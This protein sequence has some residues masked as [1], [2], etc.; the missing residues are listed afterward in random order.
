M[1]RQDLFRQYKVTPTKECLLELLGAYQ[2]SVYNLAFQVLKHAQD[3]ED[4][5]Q[6]ALLE[7]IDGANKTRAPHEFDA[8]VYRSTLRTALDVRRKRRRRAD[9]ERRGAAMRVQETDQDEL[10]E[11]LFDALAELDDESRSLV[12]QHYL[13]RRTLD[14][15]AQELGCTNVAVWKRLQKSKERLRKC[16]VGVGLGALVVGLDTALAAAESAPAPGGLLNEAVKAKA[17][18]AAAS[19]ALG[20]GAALAGTAG[21]FILGSFWVLVVLVGLLG[22][23]GWGYCLWRSRSDQH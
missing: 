16:L 19:A 8:W 22:G 14:E 15:L 9:H 3:A 17:A 21:T 5:A 23:V 4:A 6:E 13:E 2:D 11:G 7:I 18:E 12:I 10:R 1:G 20:T